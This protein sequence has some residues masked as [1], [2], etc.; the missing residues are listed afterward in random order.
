VV[1][2]IA[3]L[4]VSFV[5]AD[6]DRI[7]YAAGCEVRLVRPAARLARHA[8]PRTSTGS[9]IAALSLAGTRVLWLHYTGGNIREWS[10]WTATPA[11]RPRRLR[12]VARDVDAAPPIVLG[13]GDASRLGELLPYAVGPHV[14]VLRANGARRFAWHAPA[15]VTALAAKA[16]EVAVGLEDGRV[17]VLDGGGRVVRTE[18]FGA[19]IDAVRITGN[20]LLVQTGRSLRLGDRVFPLERGVALADAEGSRAVLVGGGKVRRLDLGRGESRIVA[21]GRTAQLEGARLVYGSGRR[22]VARAAPR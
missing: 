2:A 8:C 7:A 4:A 16:G 20:A 6:G 10:L 3:A 11:S 12:F 17:V 15:L 13:E 22:V 21:D 19:K 5:A 1:V 9:G 14:V 18:Q